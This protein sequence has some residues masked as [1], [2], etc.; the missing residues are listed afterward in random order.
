MISLNIYALSNF[1]SNYIKDN[2]LPGGCQQMNVIG[3]GRGHSLVHFAA[4]LAAPGNRAGHCRRS[5]G[6]RFNVK[7]R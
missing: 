3:T 6:T 2:Q 1:Y 5:N 4:L 7:F